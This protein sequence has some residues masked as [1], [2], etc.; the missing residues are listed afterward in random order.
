MSPFITVCLTGSTCEH[1][2]NFLLSDRISPLIAHV[3]PECTALHLKAEGGEQFGVGVCFID[4]NMKTRV[5]SAGGLTFALRH[6]SDKTT[7]WHLS[8]RIYFK[9]IITWPLGVISLECKRK[10]NGDMWMCWN[11]LRVRN[12]QEKITTKNVQWNE[13]TNQSKLCQHHILHTNIMHLQWMF[14]CYFKP[15]SVISCTKICICSA[16]WLNE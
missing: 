2:I 14:S 6:P 16:T 11:D 13:H 1:L 10:R 8:Y 5:S 9:A 12:V 4:S 7:A 15:L 3:M